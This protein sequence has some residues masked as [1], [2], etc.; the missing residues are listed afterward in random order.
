MPGQS[1]DGAWGEPIGAVRFHH[2]S[3]LSIHNCSFTN[4]GAGYALAVGDASKNVSITSSEAHFQT[5]S[6]SR[7]R[8]FSAARLCSFI[9]V[10]LKVWS[11]PCSTRTWH[12]P[13]RAELDVD[14]DGCVCNSGARC[15]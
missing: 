13:T 4:I 11:Y 12:H 2:A 8:A 10:R 3:D 14:A 5:W 7:P 1:L 15:V 9:L 6:G